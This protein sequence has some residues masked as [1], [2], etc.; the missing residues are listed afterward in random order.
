MVRCALALQSGDR[1][2]PAA[3]PSSMAA[4]ATVAY[5]RGPGSGWRGSAACLLYRTMG[6]VWGWGKAKELHWH[7]T[8]SQQR[9]TPGF[10]AARALPRDGGRESYRLCKCYLSAARSTRMQ[11][12]CSHT[13]GFG[14]FLKLLLNRFFKAIL[15]L[16]LC[17]KWL[18]YIV[19]PCK[20]ALHFS[21]HFY[22]LPPCYSQ[23]LF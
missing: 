1:V 18:G 12:K 16:S 6:Q 8:G 3:H 17:N 19:P 14:A 23:L 21:P 13:G 2:P 5:T 9:R 4:G 10:L 7:H 20:T 15:T 22:S 11:S